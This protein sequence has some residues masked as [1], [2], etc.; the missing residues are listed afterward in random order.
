MLVE[1]CNDGSSIVKD[2][3]HCGVDC[4]LEKGHNGC[5]DIGGCWNSVMR[6]ML[7]VLT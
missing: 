4:R 3:L 2:D 7:V 6:G 5:K 1:K